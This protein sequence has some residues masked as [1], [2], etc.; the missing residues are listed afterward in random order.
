M[1]ARAST[2]ADAARAM[3]LLSDQLVNAVH[4]GDQERIAGLIEAAKRLRPPHPFESLT[5]LAVVLATQ[6]DRHK[7]L[8]ERIGWVADTVPAG[9]EIVA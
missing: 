1:T 7:R 3:A 5:V 9:L 6:V 8:D 2:L 4:D